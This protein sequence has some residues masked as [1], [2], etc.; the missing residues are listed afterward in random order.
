MGRKLEEVRVPGGRTG[1]D[2]DAR[3]R[4]AIT[5]ILAEKGISETELARQIGAS[6]QNVNRVMNGGGTT[7]LFVSKLCAWLGVGVGALLGDATRQPPNET[8]KV[9]QQLARV[10]MLD[11]ELAVARWLTEFATKRQ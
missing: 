8:Q 11:D 3:L 10:A 9:I 4:K 5:L 7:L 6:Q 2:L 1:P